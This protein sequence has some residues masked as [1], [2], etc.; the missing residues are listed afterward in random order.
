MLYSF[1]AD[2]VGRGKLC[3]YLSLNL[4]FAQCWIGVIPFLVLQLLQPAQSAPLA[5]GIGGKLDL[6]VY[7]E[8]VYGVISALSRHGSTPVSSYTRIR[9][10]Q[11]ADVRACKGAVLMKQSC[12]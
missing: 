10:L 6:V 11:A 2:L 3:H 8:G 4:G 7:Q 12:C 5:E 9:K 1:R